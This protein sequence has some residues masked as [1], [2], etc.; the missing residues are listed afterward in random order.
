YGD[1]ELRQAIELLPLKDKVIIELR[2]FEDMALESI[3]EITGE[4][5]STVKSR[6]YR[7]LKKL[8]LTLE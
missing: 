4:P 6:L 2:F 8:R 3:A 5:L 7:S 1:I